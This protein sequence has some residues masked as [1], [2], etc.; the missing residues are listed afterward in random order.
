MSVSELCETAVKSRGEIEQIYVEIGTRIRR[1]RTCR[2][3][4][5]TTLAAALSTT[6]QNIAHYELGRSRVMITTLIE[7][8]R[9]FDVDLWD[10]IPTKARK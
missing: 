1:L 4:T 6:R 9:Y 2:C 7:I 3:V 8:A 10:L 5:R